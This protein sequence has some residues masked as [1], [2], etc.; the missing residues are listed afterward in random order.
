MSNIKINS[1]VV[2]NHYLDDTAI[3]IIN[4][5][6]DTFIW[7]QYGPNEGSSCDIEHMKQYNE[8]Q[9]RKM[10]EHLQPYSTGISALDLFDNFLELKT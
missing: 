2:F 8:L 7:I 9:I 10:I 3:K 1:E 6:Y 5:G 4:L